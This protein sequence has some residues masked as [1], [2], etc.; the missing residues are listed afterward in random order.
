MLAVSI[1]VCRAQALAEHMEPYEL[2]AYLCE[3]EMVALAY[4]MFNMINGGLHA[5]NNLQV[6]EFL[7]IP[8]GMSTFH[9]TMEAGS[10]FFHILKRLLKEKGYSTA[11]GDEGGFSP[12]F[13]DEKQALDFLMQTIEYMQ[14][15][16]GIS[17]LQ[18]VC[19]YDGT[20]KSHTGANETAGYYPGRS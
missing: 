12:A 16:Y 20:G 8:V 17:V 11:V 14:H 3:F 19:A 15:E 9:E 18:P 1:A 7:I 4:P 5:S 2:M 10:D 6:Q 13:D